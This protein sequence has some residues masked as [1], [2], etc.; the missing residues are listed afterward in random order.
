MAVAIALLERGMAIAIVGGTLVAVLEDL[1][2][3]GDFLELVLAGRVARILV[4]VP[5][6]R[7]LAEGRLQAGFVDRTF[8]F[9]CLIIAGLRHG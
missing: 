5:F 9:Q 7:E 2:G 1:V 8:D 3:L 6:H 4:R